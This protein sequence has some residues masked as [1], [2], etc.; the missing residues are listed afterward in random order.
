MKITPNNLLHHELIGLKMEVEKSSNKSVIGLHGTVVDETRNMLVIEV[1]D[2]YRKE[3]EKKIS[4]AMN[5]LIFELDEGTKVRV[6]GDMLISRPEDRIK[7]KW[8]IG[9]SG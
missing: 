4:K 5:T 1:E 9:I 7:K 8:G 2:E 6:R 3:K